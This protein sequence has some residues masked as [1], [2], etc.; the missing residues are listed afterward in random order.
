MPDDATG[1]VAES[2]SR[3]QPS[4]NLHASVTAFMFSRSGTDVLPQRDEG[5]GKPCAVD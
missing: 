5:S 4:I 1:G 3:L 2:S